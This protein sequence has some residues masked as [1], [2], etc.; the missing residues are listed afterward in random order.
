MTE[1]TTAILYLNVLFLL[2]EVRLQGRPWETYRAKVSNQKELRLLRKPMYKNPK[3]AVARDEYARLDLF[4]N[5]WPR[6]KNHWSYSIAHTWYGL[7][8][9]NPHSINGFGTSIHGV[10]TSDVSSRIS[11]ARGVQYF[12]EY[13]AF[14]LDIWQLS[15]EFS[16]TASSQLTGYVIVI[17]SR[18][19]PRYLGLKS[20][21]IIELVHVNRFLEFVSGLDVEMSDFMHQRKDLIVD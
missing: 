5:F 12:R 15:V 20:K 18:V 11:R 19:D 4:I 3:N 1:I 21:A 10:A 16:Q 2:Q 7:W 8:Q 13:G 9:E 14:G 17:A 6:S